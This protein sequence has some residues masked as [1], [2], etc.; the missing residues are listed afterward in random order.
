MAD[1]HWY[2]TI[3]IRGK[4]FEA[5]FV[6]RPFREGL[7]VRIVLPDGQVLSVAELGLGENALLEKATALLAKALSL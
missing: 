5:E 4:E 2:R 7:E 1:E 3:T 6:R